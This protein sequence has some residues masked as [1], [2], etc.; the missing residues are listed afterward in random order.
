M[1]ETNIQD[2]YP[3]F[4]INQYPTE[5]NP[6]RPKPNPNPTQSNPSQPDHV[7]A[8]RNGGT[9]L[10]YETV[11]GVLYM[12]PNP[13]GPRWPKPFF[14]FISPAQVRAEAPTARTD[15]KHP[16]ASLQRILIRSI[17]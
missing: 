12:T 6:T 3:K 1:S 2:Q 8:C 16:S 13:G 17:L 4:D 9:G 5:P 11:H 14:T 10:L 7:H 15:Q